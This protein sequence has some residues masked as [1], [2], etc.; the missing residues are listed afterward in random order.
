MKKEIVSEKFTDGHVNDRLSKDFPLIAT[1]ASKNE[2]DGCMVEK[3]VIG[4]DVVAMAIVD[5]DGYPLNTKLCVFEVRHD[6]RGKGYGK[7]LLRHVV[8]NYEDVRAVVLRDAIGFYRK[9]FF[10]V[11]EDR[12]GPVLTVETIA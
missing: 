12:G 8:I 9:C 4:R 11:V 2:F 7:E 1:M 5:P 3:L 6:S 10:K